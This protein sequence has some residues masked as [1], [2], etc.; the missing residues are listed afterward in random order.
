M[1]YINFI[2]S[3]ISN[4]SF[5]TNLIR[6]YKYLRSNNTLDSS[7]NIIYLILYKYFYNF[8]ISYFINILYLINYYIY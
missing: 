8:L 7:L 2:K 4:F 6:I 3:L 5:S 1:N